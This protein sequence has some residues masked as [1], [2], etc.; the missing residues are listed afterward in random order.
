MSKWT[1]VNGMAGGVKAALANE[2]FQALAQRVSD[3]PCQVSSAFLCKRAI[4]LLPAPLGSGARRVLPRG[5]RV[6]GQRQDIY[7][8]FFACQGP[9][10]L[11]AMRL[12]GRGLSSPEH[13]CRHP[14]DTCVP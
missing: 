6:T 10:L 5:R 13:G 12:Q 9:K 4:S 8:G 14:V 1:A 11:I 2:D 3:K 7:F